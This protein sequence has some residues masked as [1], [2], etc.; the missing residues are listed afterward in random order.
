MLLSS[1]D[2][3]DYILQVVERAR[4]LIRIK[5]WDA[6]EERRL[7]TWLGSLRNF[8]AELLAAFLL[9]NLSFRSRSQ[10]HSLLDCLFS[11]LTVQSQGTAPPPVS[12]LQLMRDSRKN[13]PT[14][15]V[16]L[17]PVI[18]INEPPT[19]SGPYVLRL[20]QR[21][22]RICSDWLI[23]PQQIK[24]ERPFSEIFFLDDFCG[25]GDQFV[26][27]L[28]GINFSAYLSNHPDVRVT[29]LVAAIHTEG[30]KSLAR[31][32][33]Q[34]RVKWAEC[35]DETNNILSGASLDR[36]KVPNFAEKITD[37]YHSVV[38]RSGLPSGPNVVDGYGGLGLAY[39]F[40]HA[41]PDNTLP[42]FWMETLG[43]TP[44]LDR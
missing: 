7:D 17:A 22:F 42:I 2:E 38:R 39:A 12:L 16:G 29:Y 27:F 26:E 37:Q 31:S 40:A 4:N 11:D 8:D 32:Y 14:Y 36:Y 43:L 20:A 1:D 33:P 44:L 3:N 30:I 23:W 18:G 24:S 9:D 6:V 35:L 5:V 15:S 41:T 13:R 21:Q 25:T 10:F 19:K 28:E 34:V